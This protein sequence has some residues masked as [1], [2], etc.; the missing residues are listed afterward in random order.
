[1][2]LFDGNFPRLEHLFVKLQERSNASS[3]LSLRLPDTFQ[4][5][6]LRHL[7]LTY[8][9]FPLVSPILAT[10]VY[11]ITLSLNLVVHCLPNDLLKRLSLLPRLE[12]LNITSI[13]SI[14]GESSSVPWGQAPHR[15]TPLNTHVTL[16]DLHL[17]VFKGNSAY[18]SKT[19]HFWLVT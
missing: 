4:A 5:P 2:A 8:F 18:I 17:F 15:Q 9:G 7:V 19:R 14:P 16:S 13:S 6:R 3:S 10:S 12:T 11:L 1:M